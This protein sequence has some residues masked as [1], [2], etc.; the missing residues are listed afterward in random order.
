MKNDASPHQQIV[1]MVI[2]GVRKVSQVI[3]D[4]NDSHGEPGS[5]RHI[6]ASTHASSE[7]MGPVAYSS[8]ST[9]GVRDTQQQLGKGLGFM[10][11]FQPWLRKFVTC[12]S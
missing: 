4:L 11:P 12:P 8:H 1:L 2:R 3:I 5:Q 6:D 7:L 9:S 10:I